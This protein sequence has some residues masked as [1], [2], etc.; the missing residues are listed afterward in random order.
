MRVLAPFALLASVVAL[1]VGDAGGPSGRLSLGE[2][3]S[4]DEFPL[5]YAGDEVD[6]LPLTAVLRRDDGADYVSFVYG[7]CTP[8]S[9]AGC[10][11]PA[12]V[13]VWRRADRNAGSYDLSAPGTPE[14]ERSSIRGRPAAFIGDGALEIYTDES[15]VVVF[16]G[17]RQRVLAIAR[18]LRCLRREGDGAGD[19]RL[20]CRR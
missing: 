7:D 5:F 20:E 2:A 6:G 1:V 14:V 15:T 10:A 9:D 17:T 8:G 3:R 16:A 12:E 18:A 13:Q 19:G 11:P 4:F